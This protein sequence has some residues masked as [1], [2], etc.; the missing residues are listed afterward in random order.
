MDWAQESNKGCEQLPMDGH[1]R[2]M[3]QALWRTLCWCKQVV[4]GILALASKLHLLFSQ[5]LSDPNVF[6]ILHSGWN[7]AETG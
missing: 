5:N 7:L 4:P 2:N 1:I 6:N 3:P